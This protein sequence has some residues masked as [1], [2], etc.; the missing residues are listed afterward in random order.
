VNACTLPHSLR[1]NL[2][3]NL[4]V[5]FQIDPWRTPCFIDAQNNRAPKVTSAGPNRIF[6]DADD[7][8]SR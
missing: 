1:G 3:T 2:K 4:T 6:G 5:M 7:V 8:A